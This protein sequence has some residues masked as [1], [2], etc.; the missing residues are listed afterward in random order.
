MSIIAKN[1]TNN[2]EEY[3]KLALTTSMAIQ[4]TVINLVTCNP[5]LISAQKV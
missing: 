2:Y 5:A 4:L 1:A 3:Q